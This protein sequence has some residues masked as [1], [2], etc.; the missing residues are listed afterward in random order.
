[1][2][3]L[4]GQGCSILDLCDG[5]DP[6][7]WST[8]EAFAASEGLYAMIA[9]PAG[10]TI[11]NAIATKASTGI[12]SPA[13]KL[14]F[15]DWLWWWDATNGVRRLVSPQAFAAGRLANLSPEQSALNKPLSAIA[16]SQ[17]AGGTGLGRH[18]GL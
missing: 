5:T 1:M 9:G 11:T 8:V 10:D 13:V 16:G 14:L 3:T 17:M 6:A 15:G 7:Q 2:Y 4:S 12:D 18:P